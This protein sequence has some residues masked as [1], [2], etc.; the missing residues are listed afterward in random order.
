MP[1][2]Q[3]AADPV[4]HCRKSSLPKSCLGR[5]EKNP[6]LTAATRSLVCSALVYQQ[7]DKVLRNNNCFTAPFCSTLQWS[8][9]LVGGQTAITGTHPCL[10]R[11]Q[12]KWERNCLFRE[13]N[14]FFEIGNE[15]ANCPKQQ[16]WSCSQVSYFR[17]PV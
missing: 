10:S 11:V 6:K 12:G 3:A 8:A 17:S 5:G 16:I 2:S 9:F 7:L 13:K 15:E 14:P 4:S 1:V